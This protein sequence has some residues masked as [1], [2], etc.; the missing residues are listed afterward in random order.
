MRKPLNLLVEGWRDINHSY[1]LVN[2]F[3]LLELAKRTDVTL[4]HSDAPYHLQHWSKS[5]NGAGFLAE[6]ESIISGIPK[7]DQKPDWIYRIYSPFNLH[8]AESGARLAVFIVTELGI[9]QP[10]FTAGSDLSAFLA[11]GGVFITPSHWSRDRVVDFGIPSEAVHVISHGA[12]PKYFSPLPAEMVEAQ[13]Q[14]LGFA[15]D[16]VV[17]LNI[18]TAIWNKGIDVLIKAFALARQTNKKLRLLFKDQRHTYGLNGEEYVAKILGESGLNSA[19]VLSA[20]TLIPANLTMPQMRH[21]YSVADYYVSPYRAEG[22]N[23]PVCEAIACGT[24]VIVT[25]GGATD[26]FVQGP[27]HKKIRSTLATH[28]VIQGKSISGYREPDLGHLVELLAMASRLD[29]ALRSTLTGVPDWQGPVEQ[30]LN[31]LKGL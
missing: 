5:V 30:L 4:S 6:D 19:D 7:A 22:F 12:S 31:L 14:A 17:L 13:R 1:A 24:P 28:V 8:P 11:K 10:S 2:Q 21:I 25:E 15:P 18:G 9:D 20:I 26:D 23:L 27:L 29:P 16:E 3:Q